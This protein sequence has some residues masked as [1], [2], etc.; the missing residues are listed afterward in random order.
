MTDPLSHPDQTPLSLPDVTHMRRYQAELEADKRA[1]YLSE[2]EREERWVFLIQR[3]AQYQQAFPPKKIKALAE[4]IERLLE[5]LQA[6]RH[7]TP[8]QSEASEEHP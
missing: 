1:P 5:D 3:V 6:K 2:Q 7:D 4:G 8:P